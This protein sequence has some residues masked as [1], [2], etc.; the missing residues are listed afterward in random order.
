MT[1][2]LDLVPLQRTAPDDDVDL[3]GGRATT[4]TDP[5]PPEDEGYEPTII[6]GRE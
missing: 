4:W 5:A 1:Q 3:I 6:R 2:E